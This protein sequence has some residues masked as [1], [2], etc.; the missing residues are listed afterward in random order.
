MHVGMCRW[1]AGH[2]GVCNQWGKVFVVSASLSLMTTKQAGEVWIVLELEMFVHMCLNNLNELFL[3]EL[4]P[5]LH[6]YHK[7]HDDLHKVVFGFGTCS[8]CDPVL[9]ISPTAMAHIRKLLGLSEFWIQLE[10][11]WVL[12]LVK[13]PNCNSRE[14]NGC[15]LSC[16]NLIVLIHATFTAIAIASAIVSISTVASTIGSPSGRLSSSQGRHV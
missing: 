8:T 9:V 5:S 1:H 3:F 4:L 15:S 12:S 6:W 11:F 10:A 13:V 2:M 16:N 14:F 7:C